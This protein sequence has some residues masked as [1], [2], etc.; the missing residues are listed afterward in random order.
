MKACQKALEYAQQ[1]LG[2]LHASST[3]ENAVQTQRAKVA[4]VEADL[5]TAYI[6]YLP[7]I[8]KNGRKRMV[9]RRDQF[10]ALQVELERALAQNGMRIRHKRKREIVL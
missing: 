10:K 2:R 4:K 8:S 3:E 6:K 7:L 5:Q 1:K 9:P